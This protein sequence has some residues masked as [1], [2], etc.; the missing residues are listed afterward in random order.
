M[1]DNLLLILVGVVVLI[2][3]FLIKRVGLVSKATARRL[4]AQGAVIIDVRT[5]EEYDSNRLADTV[6][7]PLDQLADRIESLARNRTAPLLLHCRSGTRSGIARTLLKRMGYQQVYNLG[8][9][10]RAGHILR[11]KQ[12]H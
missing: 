2:G 8:S 11:H 7:I 12:D 5:K 6:N 9:I 10:L 3:M 4:I 1:A